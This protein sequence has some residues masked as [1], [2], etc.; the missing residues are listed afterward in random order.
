MS[1]EPLAELKSLPNDSEDPSPDVDDIDPDP[2][3][4][5]PCRS[6]PWPCPSLCFL[7]GGGGCSL[8]LNGDMCGGSSPK[9]S[10]WCM[11]WDGCG[12]AE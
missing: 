6:F 8:N 10:G 2:E 5:E 11:G 3:E 9:C 7:P 12:W 1:P 4:R